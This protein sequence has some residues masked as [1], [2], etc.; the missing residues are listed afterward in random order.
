MIYVL[1]G[2]S[3][4]GKSTLAQQ[5]VRY[6]K[7]MVIVNRHSIREMIFGFTPETIHLYYR[8][9]DL[10]KNEKLV[11]EYQ[12]MLIK[13]SLAAGQRV[14]LDNTHLRLKYINELKK[15]EVPLTFILVETDFDT[16]LN[17]DT[18]RARQVGE[19]VIRKQ[20]AE[21]EELKK[22][23]DFKDWTPPAI[24]PIV[25]SNENQTAF[26]FDLDG[27]LALNNSG[28]SPFDWKRVGEDD[29]NKN[30]KKVLFSLGDFGYKIILCSGRD[31]VCRPET[32]EW[33]D[34]NG[35]GYRE[36]L[37]RPKGDMR[38]DSVVKEEMWRDLVTRYNILGMFDDRKQ[39]IDHARKHG[40][41][42]FDVAGNTF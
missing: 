15:Y 3:A 17:R 35:I 5:M 11:S 37:M 27:T 31:E 19:T 18:M 6:E 16:A 4:C 14:I 41:T 33:L 1:I 24:S 25:Q 26:V 10:G 28:R 22:V 13:T 38:K 42:V 8:F 36:L 20:F 34:R 32:E 2:P 29:V 7:D 9:P 12:D 23:F 40:F 21:L 39:V 30:V